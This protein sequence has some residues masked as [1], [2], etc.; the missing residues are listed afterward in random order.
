MLSTYIIHCNNEEDKWTKKT[1]G[2]KTT[3]LAAGDT[4]NRCQ[5]SGA[6]FRSEHHSPM[7]MNFWGTVG[8]SNMNFC[9]GWSKNSFP[10]TRN[11]TTERMGIWILEQAVVQIQKIQ[12]QVF[13]F[14]PLLDENVQEK[15]ST[16][17]EENTSCCFWKQK[18]CLLES[19]FEKTWPFYRRA[20]AW[21]EFKRLR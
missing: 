5:L 17:F 3:V 21:R 1:K 2:R 7:M 13:E 19:G 15:F 12:R 11:Y 8:K 9:W 18:S 16:F 20:G 4:E 14:V 6:T 10:S